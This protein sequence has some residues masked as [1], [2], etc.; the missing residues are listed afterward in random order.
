MSVEYG[1]VVVGL[2]LAPGLVLAAIGRL[3]PTHPATLMA[4]FYL[5]AAALQLVPG[6][7]HR[8][9]PPLLVAVYVA[10]DAA[11]LASL[12]W[13]R[14]RVTWPAARASVSWLVANYGVAA[15]MCGLA[16]TFP[17][18][19]PRPTFADQLFVYRVV[20]LVY[21][22]TMAGL[23]LRALV[24]TSPAAERR[25]TPL[26]AVG[27]G[28]F[29][30]GAILLAIARGD[31]LF[32]ATLETYRSRVEIAGVDLDVD[33]ADGVVVRADPERLRQA[34]VNLIENALDALGDVVGPR[35]LG[36]HV[37]AENGSG[38]LRVRDTGPGVPPDR[39]PHLFE[40]FFTTKTNGTGLGLAITKR[41]I[42][43]HGGRLLAE[44]PADGGA[45][46]IVQLPTVRVM[47]PPRWPSAS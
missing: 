10:T 33:L 34:L 24:R 19:I 37:R 4:L 21:Y 14:H 35:R 25:G 8:A 2:L 22:A 5:S 13:F 11:L 15:A 47:E 29:P 20:F 45:V 6:E 44:V 12:A 36:L 27:V 46:F 30:V 17:L 26:F 18:L 16:A 38:A 31:A 43:A 1:L 32:P 7:V 39:L 41:V 42:D 3:R 23:I 28:L 40:P 9:R